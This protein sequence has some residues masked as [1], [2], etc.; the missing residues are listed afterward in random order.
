MKK[1]ILALLCASVGYCTVPGID[2]SGYQGNVNWGTVSS[3]GK[4]FAYI[5]ATEGTSYTNPYFTQ[6]Y[7]GA[8]NQGLI[9][10]AYHFAHPDG[11]GSAQATYFL[12]HGGGWSGDGVT[13]PGALDLEYGSTSTCWGVSQATIIKFI[14]DF[15]DTYKAK[16]GRPPVIY[17]TTDWWKTCTGNSAA[18][19][20]NPLWIAR[21]SSS[22]GTLP[23]SWSYQSFWQNTDNSGVGGD[24]DIW[25][26][27]I[28]SLKK[29]AKGG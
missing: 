27:S 4:E 6:Q 22:V 3:A 18:F 23:A 5:K 9:R 7:N 17:T 28:T 12:A 16:T 21:Y 14:H 1:T 29:F 15:S 24:G 26:G 10:G 11:S 8:Y 13:L 2:V 25:N 19:S 20:E